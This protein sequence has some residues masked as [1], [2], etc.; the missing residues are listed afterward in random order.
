MNCPEDV[1]GVLVVVGRNTAAFIQAGKEI[2]DP[3]TQAKQLPVEIA[4]RASITD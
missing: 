2:F 4:L 3:V 1:L